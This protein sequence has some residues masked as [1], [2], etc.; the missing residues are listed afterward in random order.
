MKASLVA[1]AF[2]PGSGIRILSKKCWKLLNSARYTESKEERKKERRKEVREGRE[3][4]RR[5]GRRRRVPSNLYETLDILKETVAALVHS[6]VKKNQAN[7]SSALCRV[8]QVGS[9]VSP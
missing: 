8:Q 4:K 3:M 9:S 7:V 5:E 1:T 2:A 6:Q